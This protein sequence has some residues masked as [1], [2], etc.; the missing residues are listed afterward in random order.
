MDVPPRFAPMIRRWGELWGIPDLHESVTVEFSSRMTVSLGRCQPARGRVRIAARL[1]QG[2]PDLLDETLCHEVAHVAVHRLQGGRARPHG[3]TWA[4]L[5]SMAGFTPRTRAPAGAAQDGVKHP[6]RP[7]PTSARR[8]AH[9][10]PVCQ[11]VRWG[12]RPV[13]SWRCSACRADGLPGTLLIERRQHPS[14]AP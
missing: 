5:V 11:E 7:Q 10:C 1:A 12:G 13:P 14:A 9:R 8:Y 3:P 4:S 6:R 2:A